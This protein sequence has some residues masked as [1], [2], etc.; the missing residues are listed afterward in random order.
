M[1]FMACAGFMF[2][3]FASIFRI[4]KSKGFGV[5]LCRTLSSVKEKLRIL[6]VDMRIVR[7]VSRIGKAAYLFCF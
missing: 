6:R 4:L 5:L 7:A 2:A 3:S 1:V